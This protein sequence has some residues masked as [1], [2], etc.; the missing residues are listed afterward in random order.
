[1]FNTNFAKI[2][3]KRE[4]SSNYTM[5]NLVGLDGGSVSVSSNMAN[6]SYGFWRNYTSSSVGLGNEFKAGT[7][8]TSPTKDDYNLA[9]ASNSIT[10]SFTVN[11]GYDENGSPYA[12]YTVIFNN[13]SASDV[14]IT[15]V[16]F[17]KDVSSD[18]IP[19]LVMIWRKVLEE[20]VTIPA[21]TSFN[22]NIKWSMNMN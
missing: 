14:T 8:V 19:H 15:E 13:T 10:S 9:N 21:G 4:R 6:E 18:Y 1:M 12:Q 3:L 5:P 2:F 16:G 17:F 20:A 7:G 22:Y 11:V